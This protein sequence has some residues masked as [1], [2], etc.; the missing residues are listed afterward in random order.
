MAWSPG[1]GCLTSPASLAIGCELSSPNGSSTG[2]SAPRRLAPS[3]RA[4]CSCH[5]SR[6]AGLPPSSQLAAPGKRLGAAQG[7][8]RPAAGRPGESGQ[9]RP[10]GPSRTP[11]RSSGPRPPARPARCLAAPQC[12]SLQLPLESGQGSAACCGSTWRW[13]RGRFSGP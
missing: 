3:L 11:G 8:G 7:S 12:N 10:G 1:G 2:G 9:D 13:S 4:F 6:A 5:C